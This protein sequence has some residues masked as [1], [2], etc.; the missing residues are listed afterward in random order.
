M[1]QMD[2]RKLRSAALVTLSSETLSDL[3]LKNVRTPIL[4]IGILVQVGKCLGTAIRYRTREL[5]VLM[6]KSCSMEEL[7]LF[8]STSFVDLELSYPMGNRD[9]QKS[10]DG[11]LYLG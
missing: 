9:E 10:L 6:K 4:T 5:T 11:E 8:I 7:E 3:F 2:S 1:G